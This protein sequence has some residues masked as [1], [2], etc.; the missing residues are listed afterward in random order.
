MNVWIWGPPLWR[1]CHSTSFVAKSEN[2][3]PVA[4]F[5]STFPKILPCIY[6][7]KSFS[8]FF[9]IVNS[10][11]NMS[12]PDVIRGHQLPRWMYD[13]HELVNRKLERQTFLNQLGDSRAQNMRGKRLSYDCLIKRHE[14]HPVTVSP[15]DIIDILFILSLNYPTEKNEKDALD[16]RKAY[17]TFLANLPTITCILTRYGDTMLPSSAKPLVTL[18]SN[19]GALHTEHN[20]R[21]NTPPFKSKDDM[22]YYVFQLWALFHKLP[23]RNREQQY[24]KKLKERYQIVRASV[25]EHGSCK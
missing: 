24:I 20:I 11:Y 8:H 21:A 14:L 13:I 16:K 3:Q 22:F 4:D 12:L 10:A 19:M 2:A 7:R 18:Q 23:V 6:C 9:S 17:G 1:L 25:C 15:E 5:L